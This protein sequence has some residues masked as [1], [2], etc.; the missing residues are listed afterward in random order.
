[1]IL[2][3]NTKTMY[4]YGNWK[5]H[6]RLIPPSC[7]TDMGFILPGLSLTFGKKKSPMQTGVKLMVKSLD[8]I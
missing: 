5:Q 2:D 7:P 3:D 1:M 6:G 4:P 8:M